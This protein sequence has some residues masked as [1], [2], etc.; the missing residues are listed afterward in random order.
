MY[1]AASSRKNCLNHRK[2][3]NSINSN[4]KD[5]Y[6]LDSE[7]KARNK[8]YRHNR[9]DNG[10][11]GWNDKNAYVLRSELEHE[12]KLREEDWIGEG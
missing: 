11:P 3:E 8:E 2:T 7:R 1:S 6:N 12:R 4:K 5:I 10:K 9:Y